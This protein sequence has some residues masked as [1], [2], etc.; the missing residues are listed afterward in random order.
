[1]SWSFPD[2]GEIGDDARL[3][4]AP[5]LSIVTT[6]YRHAP[7]LEQCID[8]L[9]AQKTDF[10]F[11]IVICEDNSPDDTREVAKRLQAKYPHLVRI[12][13]TAK[14]KGG[15]LNMIFGVSR[16][17]APLIAFCEGDDFWVDEG[18]AARQV[19]ALNAHPEIDM[20][21]TRGYRFYADGER[22]LEWD[23]GEEARIVQLPELFAGQ[24]WIAPTASLMFRAETLRNLPP[25]YGDW[26]WG[27]PVIILSG[28]RRGGAHYDPAPTICYRIAHATSFTVDLETKPRPERIKFLEGAIRYW[29]IACDFYDFPMRHV[30]H[31][32]DDYRLAI[33]RMRLQEKQPVGALRALAGV[34]P[35]FLIGG[36]LRRLRRKAAR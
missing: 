18:K 1:M 31:R 25:S 27:D 29:K 24:G 20:A 17:K 12:V 11:E 22:A 5:A 3:P 34:K 16:A 28:A 21:F 32:V 7:F 26:T 23:Y 14:N 10:P 35:G 9:A 33:A 19:A 4:A 13:Y 6:T 36:A 30:R 2:A 15:A 8:S